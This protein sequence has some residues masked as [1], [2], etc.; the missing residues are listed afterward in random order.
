MAD[1][2]LADDHTMIREGLREILQRDDE[3]RVVDEVGDGKMAVKRA[4]QLKPHVVVM[5]FVQRLVLVRLETPSSLNV[6]QPVNCSI[7]A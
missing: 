6:V 2:L 7:P 1:V 5:S 3:F 4:S